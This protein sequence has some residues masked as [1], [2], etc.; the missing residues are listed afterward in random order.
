[1]V[2]LV[3]L[4]RANPVGEPEGEAGEVLVQGIPEKDDIEFIQRKAQFS[5]SLRYIIRIFFINR[6]KFVG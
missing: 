6:L 2:S 1:M 4:T 5:F 3:G